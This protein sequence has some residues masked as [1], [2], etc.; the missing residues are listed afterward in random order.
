MNY[1]DLR[2]GAVNASLPF[3][4]DPYKKMLFTALFDIPEILHTT[5]WRLNGKV[6]S[7]HI[8]FRDRNKV[9]LGLIAHSP[10][11]AEHSP[12]K[13]HIL[14]LGLL[15]A[16][17]RISELDLTPEGDYKDRFATHYDQVC[18]LTV[19]FSET[20]FRAK[21]IGDWARQAL[22]SGLGMSSI[23]PQRS[24]DVLAR[25]QHQIHMLIR[26]RRPTKAIITAIG[27][28]RS[29]R[30]RLILSFDSA[31]PVNPTPGSFRFRRDDL[32]DLL[33]YQ[34]LELGDPPLTEFLS[35]ALERLE[36]GDHVYTYGRDGSLFHYLW[37][38]EI[39]EMSEE[40]K[41]TADGQFPAGSYL[42]DDIHLG[43]N[44]STREWLRSSISHILQN[45]T[46]MRKHAPVY[47]LISQ[48]DAVCREVLEELGFRCQMSLDRGESDVA[49][50]SP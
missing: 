17:E 13:F 49:A 8:G 5:V 34:P 22:K 2:Q 18:R 9:L 25:C 6:I 21:K 46:S 43:L 48:H 47:A 26:N 32:N 44:D 20:R 29:T 27:K 37:L 7:A 24:A 42:L 35:L 30:E 31:Y 4:T 14:H 50:T 33:T 19:Y 1:C 23:S 11:L 28:V 10:F 15:L 38:R 3:R 45:A 39:R 16:Q 40:R 36:Q 12:G 41:R